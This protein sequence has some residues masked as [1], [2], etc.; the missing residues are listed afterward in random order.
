MAENDKASGPP[1]SLDDWDSIPVDPDSSWDNAIPNVASAPDAP[2]T[3]GGGAAS[4]DG[5]DLRAE[6]TPIPLENFDFGEREDTREIDVTIPEFA[7]EESAF[8]GP[9]AAAR[10]D[11]SW[12]A[13]ESR[14]AAGAW[15][16]PLA[17]EATKGKE[18]VRLQKGPETQAQ[19]APS[20]LEEGAPAEDVAPK[21]APDPTEDFDLDE[22]EVEK[23]LAGV[24]E[25][26]LE[27]HSGAAEFTPED[28]WDKT[29][30]P[31]V[32]KPNEP[33]SVSPGAPEAPA[34]SAGA[35]MEE[36]AP[37]A[38]PAQSEETAAKPAEM[39]LPPPAATAQAA[40][41]ASKIAD[42]A[43]KPSASQGAS[44]AAP[45]GAKNGEGT[46]DED[47]TRFLES[48]I[49][50]SDEAVPRKVELDLDGIFDQ[51][52]KEAESLSPD[53]TR[54]PVTAPLP[55]QEPE[56]DPEE[57]APPPE[58]LAPPTV[59]KVSKFKLLFML[60]PIVLG[61]L[62][63]LVG[64]YQ[65]FL[66]SDPQPADQ[67]LLILTDPLERARDPEP[68]EM[69]LDRFRMTLDGAQDSPPAV[70]EIEFILHYHDAPDA[71]VI[72]NNLIEIRDI[73]FRVTKAQNQALLNTP[74]I[75]R[76]LQADLLSTLNDLPPL[77]GDQ[78]SQVLTYVQISVLRKI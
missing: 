51:A 31:Q 21:A 52:K 40:D 48:L 23:S 60:G 32:A 44:S 67:D 13:A 53:E 68:G 46:G 41:T 2:E 47:R 73:I 56:R 5:E 78:E 69:T 45:E 62:A 49:D 59:R 37:A 9:A 75:R 72:Q 65:I 36:N 66:K 39:A 4:R 71:F 24:K 7:S 64:V 77:K 19:A 57:P 74:S 14:E 63:L 34:E 58:P 26:D 30:P 38:A 20:V 25:E 1:P 29:D 50:G 33:E 18:G 76:Q 35:P 12:G 22:G 6:G 27:G 16:D 28:S 11:D 17:Q 15:E 54:T 3:D 55:P 61:A 8:P 42:A 43:P 70:A 10:A